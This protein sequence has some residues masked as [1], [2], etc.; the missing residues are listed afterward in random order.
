MGLYSID[1]INTFLFIYFIEFILI[2]LLIL[3]IRFNIIPY[4]TA[5]RI[6]RNLFILSLLFLIVLQTFHI[7]ITDIFNLLTS[8]SILNDWLCFLCILND[9][10]CLLGLNYIFIHWY[11]THSDHLILFIS[12]SNN[13]RSL[14]INILRFILIINYLGCSL[15]INL[16]IWGLLLF[17]NVLVL[18]VYFLFPLIVFYII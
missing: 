1:N 7:Y 11:V 10:L 13:Q 9:R 8:L 6:I 4:I 12:I 16:I 15:F 3:L 2:L 17:C 18:S 14:F 5:L